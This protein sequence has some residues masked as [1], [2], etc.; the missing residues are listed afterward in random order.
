[1]NCRLGWHHT[2]FWLPVT[3]YG[4]ARR[5]ESNSRAS[6]PPYPDRGRADYTVSRSRSKRAVSLGP[7]ARGG[8]DKTASRRLV[9]IF[10]ANAAG[11]S[12]LTRVDAE[13]TLAAIHDR[14]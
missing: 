6:S 2:V 1:M 3:P 7:A 14:L 4:P 12:R 8:R 9:A 5:G 11:Y 13:A 10:A